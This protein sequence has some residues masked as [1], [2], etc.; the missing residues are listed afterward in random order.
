MSSPRPGK[1]QWNIVKNRGSRAYL[2]N[3]ALMEEI[4]LSK[5]SYCWID[6]TVPHAEKYD[7]ILTDQSYPNH[8]IEEDLQKISYETDPPKTLLE[9]ALSSAASRLKLPS[10][11]KTDLIIRIMTSDHIPQEYFKKRSKT[12][13][14]E[15]II[16]NRLRFPPFMHVRFDGKE[17]APCVISHW[18]AGDLRTGRFSLDHGNMTLRLVKMFEKMI[19][20]IAGRHNFNRYTYLDEAK[21]EALATLGINGLY[22]DESKIGRTKS[23]N[24]FGYYTQIIK[25][26][27]N[28]ILESE[29]T[30]RQIRDRILQ[31]NGFLGSFESQEDYN[32]LYREPVDKKDF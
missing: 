25:N 4:N 29:K 27:F 7:L 17:W 12:A 21:A 32:S 3:A 20:K 28:K 13:E 2:S 11:S 22:F 19:D 6:K 23:P 14:E 26:S 10:A 31:D 1:G 18:R 15:T 8:R 5:L 16:M 24:P 9:V 30:Q